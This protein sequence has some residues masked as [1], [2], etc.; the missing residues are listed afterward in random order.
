MSFF[1]LWFGMVQHQT[2]FGCR[3]SGK[4]VKMYRFSRAE[5]DNQ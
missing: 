1:N 5:E 2:Q 4:F 3:V